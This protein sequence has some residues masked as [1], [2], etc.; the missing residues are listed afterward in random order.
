MAK[1]FQDV[2]NQLYKDINT[3]ASG[4]KA[5]DERVQAELR[6]FLTSGAYPTDKAAQARLQKALSGTEWADKP[7]VF[8][9]AMQQAS[10]DQSGM[11]GGV[12]EM[13]RQGDTQ[14]LPLLERA[15]QAARQAAGQMKGVSAADDNGIGGGGP[16]GAAAVAAAAQQAKQAA[17]VAGQGQQGSSVTPQ[18]PQNGAQ[19]G[20]SNSTLP[21][22][23]TPAQ[24]AA[25]S[26]DDDLLLSFA[27]RAAGFNPN[28][29]TGMSKL[30][31]R[32][33]M[34]LLQA[35]RSAYGLMGDAS[36]ALQNVG[37]LPQDIASF[38]KEFTT[39]GADFYGNAQ[40]YAQGVMGGDTFKNSIAGLG[41][42]QQA[43]AVYQSLLPLLYAGSNP[44]VQQSAGDTF[45]RQMENFGYQDFLG[46]VGADANNPNQTG[47]GILMD[48]LNKQQNIDP[49]T[50]RIFG[51]R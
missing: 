29:V 27:L 43:G 35:R 38:A 9:I 7:G 25:L 36:G 44:L 4:N 31:A 33:L 5:G 1:T 45:R 18:G 39:K 42:A 15:R 8:F 17:G 49:V 12:A 19:Q 13:V 28:A 48:W 23:F 20:G 22:N 51:L 26:T 32:A 21:G 41:D 6:A 14:G 11:T 47:G 50:R 30:A 37:G 16:E 34:P 3:P 40:R 10:K 2:L 46:N 24:G